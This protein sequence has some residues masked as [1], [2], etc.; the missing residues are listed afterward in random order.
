MARPAVAEFGT[1]EDEV[2][3]DERAWGFVANSIGE[4][5]C[6]QD[7]NVLVKGVVLGVLLCPER[8]GAGLHGMVEEGVAKEEKGFGG[9]ICRFHCR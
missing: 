2:R 4:T 9:E 7:G 3:V 1:I 6:E 5:L 8:K